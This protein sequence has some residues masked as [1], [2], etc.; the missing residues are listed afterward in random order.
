MIFIHFLMVNVEKSKLDKKFYFSIAPSRKITIHFK[1]ALFEANNNIFYH[2]SSRFTPSRQ[3]CSSQEFQNHVH[4]NNF[5]RVIWTNVRNQIQDNSSECIQVHRHRLEP[6]Q[7]IYNIYNTIE[8][9][10]RT[11]KKT[12]ENKN[13]KKTTNTWRSRR[14]LE[15]RKR[16]E[17]IIGIKSYKNHF[18]MVVTTSTRN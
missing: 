3:K 18:R 10:N 6:A 5:Y 16:K 7:F 1:N 15:N 14:Q 12:G 11:N 13:R 17:N 4:L 9:V 8:N 2:F